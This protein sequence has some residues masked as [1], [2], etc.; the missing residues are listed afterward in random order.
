M[1]NEG[2]AFSRLHDNG[3]SSI[4]G[5]TAELPIDINTV[6]QMS[7]QHSHSLRQLEAY[8]QNRDGSVDDRDVE[9]FLRD[10]HQSIRGDLDL[11][12]DVDFQD[13]L[14]LAENFA[15]VDAAYSQGDLNCD[16]E[17]G[18]LDF[19]GLASNFGKQHVDRSMSR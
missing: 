18:F 15:L 3:F 7:Q 10:I 6:C 16:G 13:F 1:A 11:D 9:I 4:R 14:T 8:D 12:G 2:N 5:L 19:L 17:V